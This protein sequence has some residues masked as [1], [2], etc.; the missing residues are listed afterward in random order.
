M[1][2]HE[3]VAYGDDVCCRMCEARPGSLFGR[4]PCVE[5]LSHPPRTI[6]IRPDIHPEQETQ[7]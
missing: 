1:T 3:W 7:P 6:T 4:D 2:S 5:A